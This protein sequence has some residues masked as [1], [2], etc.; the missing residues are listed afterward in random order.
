M[1]AEL[2]Q[3][4]DNHQS[5]P[6]PPP[7]LVHATLEFLGKIFE[8]MYESVST[9]RTVLEEFLLEALAS[10]GSELQL[11]WHHANIAAKLLPCVTTEDLPPLLW[12]RKRIREFNP[13]LSQTTSEVVAEAILSWLRLCVLED[14]LKRLCTWVESEEYGADM[15]EEIK[16]RAFRHSGN[17]SFGAAVEAVGLYSCK[18]QRVLE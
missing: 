4:W 3:S 10:T 7:P 16:V 8:S 11:A 1:H 2:S 9:T 15:L 18:G 5:S 6:Q 17:R 13:F 14:K 12:D